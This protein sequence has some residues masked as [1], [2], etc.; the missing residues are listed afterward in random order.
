MTFNF[1]VLDHTI[2]LTVC[3]LV[4]PYALNSHV[5]NAHGAFK[6]GCSPLGSKV[7]SCS[8]YYEIS[9]MFVVH[10]LSKYRLTKAR[11]IDLLYHQGIAQA[12]CHL[13]AV[14]YRSALYHKTTV[15]TISVDR[16]DH[17]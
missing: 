3:D 12:E 8:T 17:A 4:L 7:A 13:E 5:V 11:P 15:L 14:Q 10:P 2:Y 6:Q 1:V 9:V 16:V